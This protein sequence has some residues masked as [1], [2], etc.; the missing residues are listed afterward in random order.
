MPSANPPAPSKPERRSGH[1][2]CICL[3]SASVPKPIAGRAF[4]EAAQNRILFG[5]RK[6][7]P[8]RANQPEDLDRGA[9]E[10]IARLCGSVISANRPRTPADTTGA[11]AGEQ[12]PAGASTDRGGSRQSSTNRNPSGERLHAE[13]LPEIGQNPDNCVK[14]GPVRIL[15]VH[16]HGRHIRVGRAV[17]FVPFNPTS[18]ASSSV[19]LKASVNLD[20]SL[21]SVAGAASFG[22]A[23]RTSSAVRCHRQ[24]RSRSP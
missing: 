14:A 21:A 3:I 24:L 4:T 2:Q 12:A 8:S 23:E 16:R 11:G 15:L 19:A 9:G 5:F 1:G 7:V 10:G 22:H 18:V 6:F 17:P 13:P 20:R